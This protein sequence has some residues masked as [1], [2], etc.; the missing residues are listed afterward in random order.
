MA[1]LRDFGLN[2]RADS[3]GGSQ[4]GKDRDLRVSQ[5]ASNSSAAMPAST[6]Q[7]RA[8]E[9]KPTTPP[10]TS[11]QKSAAIAKRKLQIRVFFVLYAV[12]FYCAGLYLLR[13]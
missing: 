7:D 1:D 3:T 11:E 13:K 2:E 4:Q 9:T 10:S 8:S 6:A 5:P 12:W